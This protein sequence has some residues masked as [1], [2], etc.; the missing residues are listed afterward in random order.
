[1]STPILELDDV[2]VTFTSGP[3][4]RRRSVHAMRGVSL[5]IEPGQTVG[6]VGESGSGKT[7]TSMVAL[8][9]RRP[10]S[11]VVRFDGEPFPKRRRAL[12]GRMQA[13]LQHP[14]WSLDPRQ[15]VGRSVAE[16]LT[17]LGRTDPA[18]RT[19]EI[20]AQVGL[21]ASF[22]Q[23]YPHQLSGGQRQRVS[24][25]RALVTRPPF[26]V[27]DEAV[28]A[29]DVSVQAQ[30]LNLIKDLQAELG[31]AA[32][33]ISHDLGAVRYVADRIA[34]MRGGEIVEDNDAAVFYREPEH[35]YSRQLMEAL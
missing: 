12:A 13:V 27:F 14:Q 11:G 31:F 4:L 23:R 32:L 7:T 17:V 26:L 22:A 21:D 8:G 33:F 10:A 20:L 28:S 6:L 1:M 18:G 24:I 5:R 35:E 30:I 25:A 29:L 9:L 3:P 16:P 2:T 34:V 19:E 15:R